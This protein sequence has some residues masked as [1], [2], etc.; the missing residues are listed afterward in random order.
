MPDLALHTTRLV[1]SR[2][3]WA[4]TLAAALAAGIVLDPG[5]WQL[6]AL[7]AA[8]DLALIAG[9]GRGLAREQIHPRGVRLYNA[10]H[11]PIGP[12]VLAFA[13]IWLG[14]GALLAALGWLAHVAMDRTAGYGL[15]DARGFKR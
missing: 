6:W 12:A 3:L 1:P 11:R 15:R 14:S 9:I 8:P 13:S 5:A 2:L 10:V 4:G 7:L